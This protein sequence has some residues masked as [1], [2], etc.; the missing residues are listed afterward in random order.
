VKFSV[1][2][3]LREHR[4]DDKSPLWQLVV[5]LVE[6]EC[7]EAARAAAEAF[8]AAQHCEFS[9][10]TGAEVE[11]RL[12]GV[13]EIAPVL[14]PEENGVLEV[15]SIFMSGSEAQALRRPIQDQRPASR[16]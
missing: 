7:D 1:S 2:I 6:A 3:Y 15:C 13:G 14:G 5:L 10:A 8:G 4:N 16:E 11:W 12:D 9:S